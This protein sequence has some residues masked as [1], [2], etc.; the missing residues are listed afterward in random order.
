[1][2]NNKLQVLQT[3]HKSQI[4]NK[5]Q[6]SNFKLWK[7][8]I[9]VLV[10]IAWWV[11]F[12][13]S[14]PKASAEQMSSPYY[15]I[16]MT[17]LNMTGGRKEGSGNTLTDTAGELAPGQYDS[18]GYTV[19]AGFQYIYS[20]YPFSFTISDLSIDF[21]SLTPGTPSYA[22][23]SLTV[24][25]GAAGGWQVN[26]W[27]NHEMRTRSDAAEIA[28]TEC[29]GNGE[30]C[31]PTDAKLWDDNSKYGFGYRISG[32]DIDLADWTSDNHYRPF[33]NN[34]DGDPAAII[35]EATQ[36]TKSAQ[37]TVTYKVNVSPLQSAGQYQNYIMFSALPTY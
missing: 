23:N 17:T 30:T 6:T 37:A 12:G 18:A 3:N 31:T 5:F 15:E 16:D 27:E 7:I 33:A 13:A 1:M 28:D 26:A 22:E 21:G 2:P 25:T 29:N 34:E 36:A 32:D 35:M 24:S 11:V 8:G 19:K 20:I 9:L 14:A 4:T 10:W